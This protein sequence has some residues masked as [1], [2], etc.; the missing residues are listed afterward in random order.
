M[1]KADNYQ[2]WFERLATHASPRPWQSGVA[3]RELPRS[4]L[5]RI[6]TGLGKTEGVLA[7]WL[8]HRL[9]RRDERWPRRL[10]WCLP[11]R[12]L[13]E[14]TVTVARSVCSRVPGDV[15][16]RV[17]VLMGGEDVGEWFLQPECPAVLIGTQDMLLSRAMNRGYASARARWPMEFGL[18]NQDCL[19]VMD[20]VQL[21]D[22]GLATSAQLQAFRDQ[23]VQQKKHLRPYY[24]WWMSATLQPEWLRSVDTVDFHDQWIEQPCMIPPEARTGDLWEVSKSLTADVVE[25]SDATRFADRILSDHHSLADTPHGRI[26]L[27]VCN[28]VQRAI[29]THAALQKACGRGLAHFAESS[30]QNVPV[31]LL[32]PAAMGLSFETGASWRERTQKLIQR[33]GPATLGL[34][35][36]LLRAAD[37]RASR[38][39]TEDPE[40]ATATTSASLGR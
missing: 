10:V 32:E 4:L 33:H 26:T 25:A 37:V 28:T 5:L 38:L 16:P 9:C 15:Q 30:A 22:V 36:A 35:E 13:V 14:Q 7:T 23:D 1:S 29:E 27:V 3:Q 24:T 19:W 34:L 20:E 17:G 2:T 31:P 8:Y 12:V 18:L 40:F 6:P 11:M 21:M 39:T